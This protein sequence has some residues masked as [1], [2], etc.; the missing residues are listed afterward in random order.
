[1]VRLAS[2]DYLTVTGLNNLFGRLW[3]AS[4]CLAEGDPL[5]AELRERVLCAG[6]APDELFEEERQRGSE[7]RGVNYYRCLGRQP[8]DKRWAEAQGCL[9]GQG[10]WTAYHIVWGVLAADEE[11]AGRHVLAWQARCYPLPA[12][13]EETE[14]ESDGFTDRPGVV[15]QGAR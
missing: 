13:V 4:A 5:R 11:E 6:L 7:A 8:L 14:P 15:W 12:E 9:S 2:V 1:A 10:D 3:R